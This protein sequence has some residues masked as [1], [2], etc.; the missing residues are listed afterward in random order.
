MDLGS[1]N[2]ENAVISYV[3]FGVKLT[4]IQNPAWLF[5]NVWPLLNPSVFQ[6]RSRTHLIGCHQE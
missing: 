3:N 5:L 4:W 2:V 6:L 1:C